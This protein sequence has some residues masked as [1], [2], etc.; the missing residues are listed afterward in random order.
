M[1]R[2]WSNC[3]RDFGGAWGFASASRRFTPVPRSGLNAFEA[4]AVELD[5]TRAVSGSA[6]QA[7]Q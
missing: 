1:G 5:E 6:G 3:G 4:K 7:K 2:G